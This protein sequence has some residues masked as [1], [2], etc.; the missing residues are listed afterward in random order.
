MREIHKNLEPKSFPSSSGVVA[1][2]YCKI[3]GDLAAPTCAQTATGYYRSSKLPAT[4]VNCAM[5]HAIGS[6]IPDEATT[7]QLSTT[8]EPTTL[9]TTLPQTTIPPTT[10]VPV[11][12]TEPVA[13]SEGVPVETLPPVADTTAAPVVPVQ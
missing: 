2:K 6:E 5:I 12:P 7:A 8:T 3:T 11:D 1:R 4:C 10:V 9:V 13:P